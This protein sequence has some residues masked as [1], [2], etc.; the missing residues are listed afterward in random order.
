MHLTA[1][2]DSTSNGDRGHDEEVKVKQAR[3]ETGDGKLS[4]SEQEN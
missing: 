3:N 1:V 4:N 2:V